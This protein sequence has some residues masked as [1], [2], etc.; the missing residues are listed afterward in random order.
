MSNYT[1]ITCYIFN[2]KI[3]KTISLH[4]IV[5]NTLSDH[6]EFSF[7]SS[8]WTNK[9]HAKVELNIILTPNHILKVKKRKKPNQTV[10]KLPARISYRLY[11]KFWEPL[12]VVLK[13]SSFQCRGPLFSPFSWVVSC[14]QWKV[15]NL[16]YYFGESY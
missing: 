5:R 3:K 2:S 11:V 7:K 4:Q 13:L 10:L 12:I 1:T 8:N 6:E 14:Q 9:I 16:G 15:Q